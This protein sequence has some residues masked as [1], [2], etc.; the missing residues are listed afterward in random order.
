MKKALFALVFLGLLIA[1]PNLAVAGDHKAGA[2]GGQV[3]SVGPYH[4]EL[5][6]KDGE[7][8]LY[9]TDQN[10]RELV[11]T[12]GSS[13]KANIIDKDG[14][15]VRV[16][17]EP[18]FGNLMKGSGDFKITPETT[19]SVFVSVAASKGTQSARFDSLTSGKSSAEEKAKGDD[20]VSDDNDKESDKESD[21]DSDDDNG[22]S[23]GV[24]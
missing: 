5:V 23:D 1:L 18:V 9:V 15:R 20:P 19:V 3:Q 7:L 10:N 2:H 11:E 17:L 14:N 8:R 13:G 12:R 21:N 22:S 16:K 4:L 6:A 24:Y